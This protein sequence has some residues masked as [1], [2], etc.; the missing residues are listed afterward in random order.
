MGR[1]MLLG[2]LVG[3][4]YLVYTQMD[5]EMKQKVSDWFKKLPDMIPDSVKNMFG[6]KSAAGS[7]AAAGV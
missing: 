5:A 4:A 1:I 2:A 7:D 6:M 3:G